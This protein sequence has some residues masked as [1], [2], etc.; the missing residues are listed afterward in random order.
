M[1]QNDKI[2]PRIG[3]R[4]VSA[5]LPVQPDGHNFSSFSLSETGVPLVLAGR[6]NVPKRKSL[7]VRMQRIE[8]PCLD[9]RFPM[10][11]GPDPILFK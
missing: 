2:C 8:V 11:F 7:P 5:I 10:H 3:G 4:I 9:A 6:P 1:A